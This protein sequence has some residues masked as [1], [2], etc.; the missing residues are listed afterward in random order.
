MIKKEDVQ[1]VALLSRLKL[2]PAEIEKF[3]PQLASVFEMFERLDVENLKDVEETSQVTGLENVT[4]EDRISCEEDRTCCTSEQ[5]LSN[6][7]IEESGAILV[8]K[9]LEDK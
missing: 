6:A 4:R 3:T 5:L 8:P 1:H 9:V 2:E 7:P